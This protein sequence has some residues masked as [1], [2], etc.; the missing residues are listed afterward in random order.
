[1]IK[2]TLASGI[3]LNAFRRI[4]TFTHSNLMRQELIIILAAWSFLSL[5]KIIMLARGDGEIWIKPTLFSSVCPVQA[6]PREAQGS[7]K[8]RHVSLS[9]Q[10]TKAAL[11]WT[12]CVDLHC[13]ELVWIPVLSKGRTVTVFTSQGGWA[14]LPENRTAKHTILF[15]TA[16]E[17][18]GGRK[19]VGAKKIISRDFRKRAQNRRQWIFKNRIGSSAFKKIKRNRQVLKC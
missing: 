10:I 18:W 13:G 5:P 8:S 9:P 16:K 3:L 17:E 1:M 12:L 2:T 6:T 14:S 4:S 15:L 11:S 19:T 7:N